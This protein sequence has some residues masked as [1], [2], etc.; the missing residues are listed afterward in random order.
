[1]NYAATIQA[2][3]SA[4][5]PTKLIRDG[6]DPP[7]G[8]ASIYRALVRNGLIQPRPGGDPRP[9][10]DAGNGPGP[11]SYGSWTSWVGSG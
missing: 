10:T 11:W 3:A 9:T 6:I 8:L 5:W 2:G 1:M 4:A 7:P